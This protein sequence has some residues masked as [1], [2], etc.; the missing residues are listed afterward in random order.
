MK[1]NLSVLVVLIIALFGSTAFAQNKVTDTSTSIVTYWNKGDRKILQIKQ[2]KDKFQNG[3]LK[4]KY[5]STY[6]AYVNVLDATE[7]SYT[8]EWVYKNINTDTDENP[9]IKRMFKLTEGL[10]VEYTTDELGVFKGLI[11]WIEI[12]DFLNKSFDNMV[13]D[14]KE[15]PQ[16]VA[17][18]NQVRALYQSKEAIENTVIK[19][20][21]LYHFLY[22]GTYILN[23][24]LK[25]ETQIP[26]LLGGEP[27]PTIMI[28]EMTDLK[29]NNNY[30]KLRID[31]KIDFEKGSAIVN[32]FIK[33][34]ATA[35]GSPIKD[36][37][38]LPPFEI[39]DYNEFEAELTTGWLTKAYTKRLIESNLIK[40]TETMEI[41]LQK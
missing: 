11:N 29:P 27:F 1:K 37:Q 38:E 35:I 32:E 7:K 30:C 10:R 16:A 13:N 9:I 17:A 26:N 39:S 21:Q 8:I 33:K 15:N 20:I 34:M 31:Q 24:K 6:E 3:V 5:S 18:F 12:R 4:S 22:G 14:F 41:S 25:V 40:Q 28:I 2:S 36:N 23:E 19:D